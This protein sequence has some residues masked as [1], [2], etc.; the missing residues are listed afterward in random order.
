MRGEPQAFGSR[1]FSALRDTFVT[2]GVESSLW[3]GYTGNQ[4]AGGCNRDLC[5]GHLYPRLRLPNFHAVLGSGD[6]HRAVR[7]LSPRVESDRMGTK[8]EVRLCRRGS[9]S[10][11]PRGTLGPLGERDFKTAADYY[12]FSGYYGD[13]LGVSEGAWTS[14]SRTPEGAWASAEET[15]Q[16]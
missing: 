8:Q 16:V 4:S 1:Q 15:A 9:T 7:V 5:S 11:G 12:V 3:P 14:A 13:E 2:S 6:R 10:Q